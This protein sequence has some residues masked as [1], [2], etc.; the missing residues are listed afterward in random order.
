[1]ANPSVFHLSGWRGVEL[2]VSFA[3]NR[4]LSAQDTSA[5][6]KPDLPLEIAHLLLIDVV[7]YSK[8]LVNEQIELLQ[9]LNRVV[10]GTEC[11]QEAE[12]A[13]KLIR[14]P[15]GDGM[16]LLFFRSPEEPVQCA[17]AISNEL[18]KQPHIQLR[19][20]IHSGPVNQVK[21]VNET[22][23]VAGAGINVAQRV[24]DCG[25]AGHI[26]LSKH[27]ADDLAEYRS[28]QPFLRDLGEC[29][30]KHG[31]RLHIFNLCKDGVGNPHVPEKLRR[32]RWGQTSSA[33]IRPI[34]GP[35]WPKWAAGIALLGCVIAIALTVGFSHFFK[36]NVV[37]PEKSIAVLPF[38]NLSDDKQNAYFADGVQ[39]EILTNLAKVADLKVISR[40][41]VMQYRKAAERNLRGIA[42]DLGVA[43]ILEGTVQRAGDLVRVSAQLINARTDTHVWGESYKR[44]AAD[45]FTIENEVAEKIVDQLKSRLSPNEK[46]AIEEKPTADLIAYDLY[47]QAR[48]LIDHAVF[49]EPKEA[50]LLEAVRLLEQAVAHD[51]KFAL[52]YYQLAHAHDQLYWGFIDR[53]PRRLAL[54]AAAIESLR[55]LR[56]VSGETHLAMAK[57]LYWGYLD[58]DGA[59]KELAAAATVMPNDPWPSLLT[60]YIDRRQGRWEESLKNMK[61]A[62]DLD[63][64]NPMILLQ[65][66]LSYEFLRRYSEM[67]ATLDRALIIVP[68]DITMRVRHAMVALAQRADPGPLHS[69][70][71]AILAENPDNAPTL[72]GDWFDLALAERDAKAAVRA[73]SAIPTSGYGIEGLVF[74]RAWC[75]GRVALLRGDATA[76]RSAFAKARKELEED[77]RNQGENGALLCALGSVNAGLGDKDKAIEEGRRAVELLPVEKDA[78]D[79]EVCLEFMAAIYAAVGDKEA[80]CHQLAVAVKL[81]GH[82]SYGELRLNP[83]WDPLRGDPR[84]EEIVASLAPK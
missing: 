77:I 60:G 36:S 22:I 80:A 46:A 23:N 6:A 49:N 59:R 21:D 64:R 74:P 17:V 79:G 72:A 9:E 38:Q 34:Y 29:E 70:I 83:A 19:M 31:L 76:A 78:I 58:Y 1:M 15:T 68:T 51:P 43:F 25:D 8:L 35:R 54:A 75:E 32:R 5:E 63:P 45:V 61:R 30:A 20:G 48:V 33:T 62:S 52:A 24:M 28:W 11:F 56:P 84:F 10:R 42:K 26:L 16:A 67:T 66:A 13:G 55:R 41:S 3:P 73:L 4:P 82:L 71:D 53:T 47:A 18:R 39:D 44:N 69:V 57:H 12:K 50:S 81:P 65:I 37:I 14:L 2:G 7:G 40:T 27:V